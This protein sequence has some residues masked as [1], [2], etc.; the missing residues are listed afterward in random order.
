[1]SS[2]RP[3]CRSSL[4][5][6]GR[7]A[8]QIHQRI[9][10]L[11]V[12]LDPVGEGLQSP[13]LDPADGASVRGDDALVVI[14]E[15]VDLLLREVLPGK[16]HMFVESH[17]AFRLSSYLCPV[18][19]AKPLQPV[20]TVPSTGAGRGRKE[21]GRSRAETREAEGHSSLRTEIFP[22]LRPSVQPPAG[23]GRCALYTGFRPE[24][25]L[26]RVNAATCRSGR[27]EVICL[28]RD[29]TSRIAAG[30]R[31]PGPS[32][33]RRLRRSVCRRSCRAA[34]SGNPG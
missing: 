34:G 14:H 18:P 3:C 17:D 28:R 8:V 6:R 24:R 2:D 15:R 7:R 27:P 31:F 29:I 11:P 16:K 32:G 21:H 10:G 20:L 4:V 5:E 1:M 25:K 33:R 30:Q 19:A 13:V 9:V 22:N 26:G 12:L 23:T